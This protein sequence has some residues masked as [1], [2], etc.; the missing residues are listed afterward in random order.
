MDDK[1][2][3]V[4]FMGKLIAIPA[5]RWVQPKSNENPTYWLVLGEATII[6]EKLIFHDK[7]SRYK[8]TTKP[9]NIVLSDSILAEQLFLKVDG[10]FKKSDLERENT[11]LNNLY[12]TL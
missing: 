7:E 3:K 5:Y 1:E 12:Q 8:T 10:A 6:V 4:E 2:K 9:F 11:F